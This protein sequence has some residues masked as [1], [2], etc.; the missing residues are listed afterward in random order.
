MLAIAASVLYKHYQRL[1]N[2]ETEVTGIPI[3]VQS[4]LR[5]V[6]QLLVRNAWRSMHLAN[7]DIP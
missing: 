3:L 4:D 7:A 2:W 6:Q 5:S 1:C